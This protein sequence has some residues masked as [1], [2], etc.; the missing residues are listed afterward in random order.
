MNEP[1]AL[2]VPFLAAL[3]FSAATTA[4]RCAMCS[5]T[6]TAATSCSSGV[7]GHGSKNIFENHGFSFSTAGA[8]FLYQLL[9][10]VVL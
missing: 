5:D 2:A 1:N 10:L 9:E 7:R 8:R 6:R 4:S 3:A